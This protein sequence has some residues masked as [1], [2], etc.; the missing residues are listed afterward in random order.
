MA[1]LRTAS[2]AVSTPFPTPQRAPH[3]APS[4]SPDPVCGPSGDPKPALSRLLGTL[5]HRA[6]QN[7]RFGPSSGV[8]SVGAAERATFYPTHGPFSQAPRTGLLPLGRSQCPP[9]AGNAPF[10]RPPSPAAI[11]PTQTPRGSPLP[12]KPPR[13]C[14]LACRLYARVSM[15]TY[16]RSIGPSYQSSGRMRMLFSNCSS[17]C[18][19]QPGMRPSAKI[20]MNRSS[21]MPIR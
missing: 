13:M 12:R 9:H 3:T 8:S 19:V 4:S 16:S 7:A 18:S 20:G 21:G 5:L 10:S 11:D 14:L 2:L 17:T 15:G 1:V 6:S